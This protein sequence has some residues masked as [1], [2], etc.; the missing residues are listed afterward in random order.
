MT[1]KFDA[2]FIQG[3]KSFDDVSIHQITEILQVFLSRPGR[4]Y[5]LQGSCQTK[6]KFPS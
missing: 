3:L 5:S 4:S 6:V 2:R 1:K